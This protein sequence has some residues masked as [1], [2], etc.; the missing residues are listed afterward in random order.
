LEGILKQQLINDIYEIRSVLESFEKFDFHANLSCHHSSTGFPLGC[1]GDTTNMLGLYLK[2]WHNKDTDYV[3]A[4]GLGN[5]ENQSHSW[6][7]CDG[8]IV[9]ITADQ[10]NNKGYQLA[11]VIIAEE[12]HFHTLFERV[13]TYP[14][15]IDHFKGKP[16][17]IVLH[18]VM[19]RMKSNQL[20]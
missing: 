8:F 14:L 18:T 20:V 3:F 15:K 12:S 17:S 5:S 9:D 2:Q 4:R 10:F 19:S 11:D 6:L 16:V 1:C 13:D 7:I